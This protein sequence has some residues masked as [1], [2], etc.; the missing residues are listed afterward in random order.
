VVVDEETKSALYWNYTSNTLRV[1]TDGGYAGSHTTA[2]VHWS[3]V[4]EEYNHR[5]SV[6]HRQSSFE[7]ELAAIQV[8]LS[9]APGKCNLEIVT[10]CLGAVAAITGFNKWK[11]GRQE[12]AVG[13]S[14]IKTVKAGIRRRKKVGFTIDFTYVPS[15]VPEKEQWAQQRGEEAVAK[16]GRKI[17]QLQD[18]HGADLDCLI[19][20]NV[21]AD[22]LA[23]RA[24]IE[25]N[26]T[27]TR[28]VRASRDGVALRH[29]TGRLVEEDIAA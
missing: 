8:A 6:E 9:D 15:H 2:G 26:T 20:G 14:I 4:Q 27:V 25:R 16:W 12:K 13:R 24:R 28:N 22:H 10:D 17:R 7:G 1:W 18:R 29:L 21:K 23:T 11:R 5:I 19:A 3:D